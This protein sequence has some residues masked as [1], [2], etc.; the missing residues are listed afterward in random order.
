[1]RLLR[2]RPLHVPI[3]PAGL[4]WALAFACLLPAFASAQ[5]LQRIDRAEFAAVT[6][7]QVP[8]EAD[9]QPVTLPDPWDR[10]APPAAGEGWYRLRFFANPGD[11]PWGLYLPRAGNALEIRVNGRRVARLG[12][13]SDPH[14][15]WTRQPIHVPLS[16][17]AIVRGDNEVL[18]RLQVQPGRG[19][20]LSGLVVG[21]DR[22]VA[23]RW[24]LRRAVVVGGALGVAGI[25]GSLGLLAL[26]L[27]ARLRDELYL[28]FGAG[29]LLWA[30]RLVAIVTIEPPIRSEAAWEAL[31]WT[32]YGAYIG[33]MA[34][35][36]LR[37]VDLDRSRMRPVVL[38][39]LLINPLVCAAAQW[40]PLQW[41]QQPW[42]GVHVLMATAIG[43]IVFTRAVRKPSV[44]TTL[45]AGGIAIS[46]AAG[47]HDWVQYWLRPA[48]YEAVLVARHVSLVFFATMAWILVDRFSRALR[49]YAQLNAELA[50]RIA[51]AERELD[52]Q[53]ALLREADRSATRQAERERIVRDLHDGIGGQLVLLAQRAGDDRASRSELAEQLRDVLLQMRLSIES[54]DTPDGDLATA[55]A[56]VRYRFG[57]R[58][59]SAGVDSRWQ[60]G[61][62]P[63]VPALGASGVLDVQR[64]LLEAMT[65]AVRHGHARRLRIEVAHRDD[66]IVM[67]V[68]DDGSGFDTAT[69]QGGRGLSN[70]RHRARGLGA[71][72]SIDSGP[73]GTRLTLRLPVPAAD[74]GDATGAPSTPSLETPG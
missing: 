29:S 62:L 47:V 63:R 33:M 46:V 60:V 7:D 52:R 25:I 15:D 40:P 48:G 34:L 3:L 19:G 12:I 56:N 37:V 58:L 57:E 35:F 74:A 13:D 67:T 38:A 14:A 43:A 28:V 16:E 4:L 73:D 8:A 53:Y 31:L 45:L 22:E 42:Q 26:A 1:M 17:G 49:G 6:G 51:A 27:W 2:R 64:I 55:L 30:A 65:N 44:D 71:S 70:M 36:A 39:Y 20:G 72:L 9:W 41:L 61:D 21:P 5:E 50:D 11:A 23:E 18:I 66:A 32:M 54:L 10:R 24:G 68:S 69:V 59:R